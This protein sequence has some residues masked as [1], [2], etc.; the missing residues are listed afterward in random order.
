MVKQLLKLLRTLKTRHSAEWERLVGIGITVPGIV[1]AHT[2]V[3]KNPGTER[4]SWC[5]QPFGA[6]IREA[7]G[8]PVRVENNVR[9]RAC[10]ISPFRPN[11]LADDTTFAFCHVGAGHCL[12]GGSEQ[13]VL[14][15]AGCRCR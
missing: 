15:R 2:G 11:L 6:T 13:S 10:A 7:T 9:A 14:P 12:P 3:I 5:N 8:L 4:V 1:N